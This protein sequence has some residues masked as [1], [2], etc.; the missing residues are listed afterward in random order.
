RTA[1]RWRWWWWAR[2]SAGRACCSRSELLDGRSDAPPPESEA[3]LETSGA[4]AVSRLDISGSLTILR[5]PRAPWAALR[6]FRAKPREHPWAVRGPPSFIRHADHQSA[7]PPGA[8][9]QDLQDRLPRAE[10]LPA[11]PRRVRARLH[12]H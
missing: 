5:V 12:H 10:G 7:H 9:R 1:S 4:C 6:L 2:A 8:D 11:A 3:R